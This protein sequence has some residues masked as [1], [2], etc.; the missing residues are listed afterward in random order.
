MSGDSVFL[1][2]DQS[3][4]SNHFSQLVAVN[5]PEYKTSLINGR[6]GIFV[7]G[8]SWVQ[9]LNTVLFTNITEGSIWIVAQQTASPPN[10]INGGAFYG[11]TQTAGPF[12]VLYSERIPSTQRR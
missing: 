10:F 12:M 5:Q 7:D 6:P 8:A 9:L 1:W 4:N 3:G 2:E 11:V